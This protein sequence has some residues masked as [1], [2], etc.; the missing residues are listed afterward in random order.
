M[1]GLPVWLASVTL[2][3]IKG[4]IRPT[5]S[6]SPEDMVCVSSLLDLALQGLGDASMERQFRM[7][8]TVCRHRVLTRAEADRLPEEWWTEPAVAIAGG[9]VELLWEKG[10][11]PC[12]STRPCADPIWLPILGSDLTVPID[13]GEC[14][15][16]VARKACYGRPMRRPDGAGMAEGVKG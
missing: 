3:D 16:C 8:A 15:S 14:A 13:C 9:P 7:N 12:V 10:I 5:G 11:K 1:N 4:A 6:F 2:R